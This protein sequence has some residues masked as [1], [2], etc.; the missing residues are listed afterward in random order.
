MKPHQDKRPKEFI[1]LLTA[2][3][4]KVAAVRRLYAISTDNTGLKTVLTFVGPRTL[5]LRITHEESGKEL[6]RFQTDGRAS[7]TR[8]PGKRPV[9]AKGAVLP[10]E[11]PRLASLLLGVSTL[12]NFG[13][14]HDSDGFERTY[15]VD[16]KMQEK[17]PTLQLTYRSTDSIGRDQ[18][19]ELLLD[20]KTGLP[21]YFS[22]S[23]SGNSPRDDGEF[24]VW[25]RWS[26][27]QATL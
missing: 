3:P 11:A 26:V 13:L 1:E 7:L 6:L 2:L 23:Q 9:R 21:V 4:K 20:E 15:A 8:R 22:Y 14:S 17:R 16:K 25:E 5:T 18:E 10:S 19:G 24:H 12:S 27:F